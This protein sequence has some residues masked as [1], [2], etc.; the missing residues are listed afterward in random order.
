M[1]QLEEVRMAVSDLLKQF[2]KSDD[3][4]VML[5]ESEAFS[6]M[7]ARDFLLG[8]RLEL[9]RGTL[10]I[11][12]DCLINTGVTQKGVQAMSNQERLVLSSGTM[13]QLLTLDQDCHFGAH[14]S[15]MF[16]IVGKYAQYLSRNYSLDFPYG[17]ESLFNDLY[18]MDALVIFMGDSIDCV[19]A[20]YV[21]SKRSDASIIKNT[22]HQ[23]S[24]T[25]SYLDYDFNFD[26]A[27]EKLLRADF[28]RSTELGPYTLKAM[29]YQDMIDYLKLY[30]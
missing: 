9:S 4:V 8:L 30:Y 2:N 26:V 20:K 27:Q 6:K 23:R 21:Q 5:H 7:H 28:I 15:L 11:M 14:P 19:E 3:A 24:T 1:I 22:S 25:V 29:L 18:S 13:L 10:A 17:S 16:G 12:G